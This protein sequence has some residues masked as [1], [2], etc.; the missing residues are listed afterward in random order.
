MKPEQLSS[1]EGTLAARACLPLINSAT[2][3][4]KVERLV[5][6]IGEFDEELQKVNLTSYLQLILLHTMNEKG[7]RKISFDFEVAAT[8]FVCD[9]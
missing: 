9:S 8:V 2:P 6:E 1:N 7:D 5:E 4:Q 3:S